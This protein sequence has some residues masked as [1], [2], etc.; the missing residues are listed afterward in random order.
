MNGFQPQQ[1]PQL[2]EYAT[3]QSYPALN[4]NGWPSVYGEQG[5]PTAPAP[6]SNPA[7]SE[8]A[9]QNPHSWPTDALGHQQPIPHDPPANQELSEEF[10]RAQLREAASPETDPNAQFGSENEC[11]QWADKWNA[12]NPGKGRAYCYRMPG[13]LGKKGMHG[14]Q[15]EP[16]RGT[17]VPPNG[18]F[19]RDPLPPA[20][21][22]RYNYGDESNRPPGELPPAGPSNVPTP[23]DVA[24]F[25]GM[26]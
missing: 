23:P 14:G 8:Y 18:Q 2:P 1:I 4:Q 24:K 5:Q 25:D 11:Q 12:E 9:L 21:P 13:R 26:A 15:I 20:G 22:Y 19:D 6:Q 17:P 10:K 3:G 16:P 7:S